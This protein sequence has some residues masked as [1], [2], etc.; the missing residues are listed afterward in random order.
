MRGLD[1]RAAYAIAKVLLLTERVKAE[2]T[3]FGLVSVAAC[4][5]GRADFEA[6]IHEP[7]IMFRDEPSLRAGWQ[8][9][10]DLAESAHAQRPLR[11]RHSI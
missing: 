2:G 9:G 8:R 10:H 6:G 4:G 1:T 5:E 11:C 7:P 3:I